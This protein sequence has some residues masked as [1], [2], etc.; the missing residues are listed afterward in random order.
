VRIRTEARREA[1]L[2]TAAQAFMELGYDGTSMAIIAARLGGSKGT[3]YGYFPSKEELFMGV[4][5]HKVGSKV[6]PAYL[7]LARHAADDPLDV[8]QHL[9]V[10]ILNAILSP[11]AVALKRLVIA[12]M[13]NHQ[14][15]ERF[16]AS[17][18]GLMLKSVE[19]YLAAAT[20]AGML[21]VPDPG[22]AARHLL[23]LFEAEP[24]WRGPPGMGPAWAPDD[25]RS[26]VA[27]AVSVFLAAY[28]T[29]DDA[30]AKGS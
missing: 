23:A 1:I 6:E 11:D 29:R 12:Q 17:G 20:S 18:P 25:M 7:N 21:Q 16:W 9:G 24:H 28:G 15:G 19:E 27:R 10:T 3:L 5:T 2:E 13:N 8:L 4:V 30:A 26:A 14:A 22:V